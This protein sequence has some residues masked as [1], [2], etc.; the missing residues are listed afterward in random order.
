MRAC[1]SK[2]PRCVKSSKRPMARAVSPIRVMI[3]AFRAARPLAGSR[4]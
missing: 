4:Y 2:V 1:M 3:N